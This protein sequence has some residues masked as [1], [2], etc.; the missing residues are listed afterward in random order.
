MDDDNKFYL[1][2]WSL[3][4]AVIITLIASVTIGNYVSNRQMVQMVN[5]GADPL[6]ARCAITGDQ[7]VCLIVGV[8]K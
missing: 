6:A 3:V 7:Q 4:A 5:K 2:I 1:A 8:R